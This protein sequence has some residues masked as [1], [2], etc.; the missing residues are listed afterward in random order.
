V[1][2]IFF[3]VICPAS[4]N[5]KVLVNDHVA[6]DV[7]I[8]VDETNHSTHRSA[9]LCGIPD[10]LTLIHP[11]GTYVNI[12]GILQTVSNE[13]QR[14]EQG[15]ITELRFGLCDAVQQRNRLSGWRKYCKQK[16]YSDELK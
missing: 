11:D 14:S 16:W 7:H 9:C 8:A 15:I 12:I 4:G 10:S 2:F 3:I 1:C 5:E 6:L 13:A